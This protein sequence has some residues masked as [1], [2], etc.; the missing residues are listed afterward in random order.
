MDAAALY[1]ASVLV[2]A[3]YLRQIGRALP[4]LGRATDAAGL[5]AR[6]EVAQGQLARLAVADHQKVAGR[7]VAHRAE[8]AELRQPAVEYV[9][10]FA[11]PGFSLR[12]T[13]GDAPGVGF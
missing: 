5:V 8:Q 9:T 2:F 11:L 4:A 6:S 12:L 10:L 7:V 3:R 1:A 13:A